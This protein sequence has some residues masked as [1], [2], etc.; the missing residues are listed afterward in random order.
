[1]ARGRSEGLELTGPGGLL[2][3]VTK[4]VLEA[5]LQGDHLDY[6]KHGAAGR[7]GGNSRNGGDSRNGAR[8]KTVLTDIGPV[9]IEVPCDRE[10]SFEPKIV[11]GHEKLPSDGHVSARWRS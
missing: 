4:A 8:T 7:D 6:A 1:M 9:E 5:A 10:V 2:G 3:R 11:G